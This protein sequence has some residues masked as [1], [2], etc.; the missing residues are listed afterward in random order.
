[1][2]SV[3]ILK[4][5][6]NLWIA[7]AIAD[8]NGGSFDDRLS[9]IVITATKSLTISRGT[10]ERILGKEIKDSTWHSFTLNVQGK[11]KHCDDREIY[12]VDGHPQDQSEDTEARNG[13]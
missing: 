13:Q 1:M 2:P 12:I 5:D 10:V 8:D 6:Q 3:T 9:S 11:V 7:S 4:S